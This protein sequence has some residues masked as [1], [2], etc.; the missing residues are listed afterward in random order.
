MFPG[1]GDMYNQL[2]D[3]RDHKFFDLPTTDSS[4][5]GWGKGERAAGVSVHR[6]AAGTLPEQEPRRRARVYRRASTRRRSRS[7]AQLL[8]DRDPQ[9]ARRARR[10]RA[11]GVRARPTNTRA[12]A[13]PR[14]AQSPYFYEEDNWTDDMELGAAELYALTRDER[15]LRQRVEYAAQEPVTPWMGADTARHYQWFPWHNAGHYALWR[16]G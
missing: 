16:D 4:D 6:P 3:D 5:Y 10:T 2:A 8:K 7:R 1:D 9:F 13:R 11:R 12:C 15:Y 14:P